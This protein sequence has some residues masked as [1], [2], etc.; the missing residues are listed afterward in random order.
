MELVS[1][2]LS[3]PKWYSSS[4][5]KEPCSDGLK[6]QRD[7]EEEQEALRGPGSL[8]PGSLVARL[9]VSSHLTG[10]P[11]R[12]RT[13]EPTFEPILPWSE[14]L[15]PTLNPPQQPPFLQGLQVVGVPEVRC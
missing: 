3:G 1:R 5:R 4:E 8:L 2:Q 10:P 11:V 12:S 6:D 9:R 14:P 7:E 13:C 15:E